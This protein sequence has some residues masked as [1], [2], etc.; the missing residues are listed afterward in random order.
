MKKLKILICFIIFCSLIYT[1]DARSDLPILCYHQVEPKASG[2]YSLN[3][4]KFKEQLAYLKTRKYQTV[5]S[6]GLLE[7]INGTASDTEKKIAIT[8]DDGYR[9]VY[10]YAFPEMKKHGFKGIVCIY[11]EFIGSRLAM[12]W[13]ELEELISEGWSVEC[14]SM[15]HSN[16]SKYYRNTDKYADFLGKEILESKNIIEKRVKNKV[17]LMVWPYGVYTDKTIQ[18]SENSGFKGA[19]TVDGG[20]NY[21]GISP[22]LI[23]RQI[24]YSTDSMNKFLIRL[25]MRDIRI[26]NQY[27]E[28]GQ[29]I[30]SLATFSCR[31]D[32]LIDYSPEKYVLNAKAT[33]KKVNFSFDPK[34]RILV[35]TMTTPFKKSGNY[36]I[37]V[38]LR[39]KKTG[40]T[41]QNG[42][43]FTVAP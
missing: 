28:P 3:L 34:T 18:F 11:P 41:A 20:G 21:V 6:D 19:M 36:F 17:K 39:D 27:P 1:V 7:Y 42:W 29:V 37:D 14:H 30:Q 26:S 31:I 23:K 43:L 16:L 32:D 9:T 8:F 5:N 40:I 22:W 24:V 35:A 13:R 2:K 25:G 4:D 38:Y 33:G 10:D 12:K 15:S